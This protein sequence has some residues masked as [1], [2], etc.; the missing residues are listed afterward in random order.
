MVAFLPHLWGTQDVSCSDSEIYKWH[1]GNPLPY[2]T[3][4]GIAVL[5]NQ[6]LRARE[7]PLAFPWG[8][9][10]LKLQWV[11]GPQ[12]LHSNPPLWKAG[13]GLEPDPSLSDRGPL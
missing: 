8:H 4:S 11:L 5:G 13:M 12:F 2:G 9:P 3:T 10:H 7:G 6:I 1:G